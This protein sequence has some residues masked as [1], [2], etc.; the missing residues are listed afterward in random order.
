MLTEGAQRWRVEVESIVAPSGNI[1][2]E[3][4]VLADHEEIA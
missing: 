4:P 1:E 3:R 2:A